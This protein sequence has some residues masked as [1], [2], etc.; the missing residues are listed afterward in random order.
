VLAEDIRADADVPSF[1][2]SAMDGYAVIAA[3]T[4]GATRDEPRK[5]T[6]LAE[7]PAGTVVSEK[8]VPGTA[9]RIM[10][11]A[12][13]PLGAD[14]VVPFEETDEAAAGPEDTDSR[15]REV[16]I[17]RETKAGWN[18]RPAG[19]DVRQG[20]L[21]MQA[22]R[23]VRPSELGM[24]AA[25]GRAQ[26]EV[27]RKARVAVITSGNELADV[28]ERPGPGQIRDSNQYSLLGQVLSTGAEVSAL[29]R[30]IDERGELERVLSNAVEISDMVIVS[31]GV[32]VGDYDFVKDTLAKL[33]DIRFWKVEIKPGK[34][35][36][37]GD[38]MG[39]PLFGLPGNPVS[40]MVTFDVFVRPAIKRM[41]GLESVANMTV[42][43]VVT[44]SVRHKI[45]RREFVRATTVWS[46]AGYAATP[47]G[48]QGSG[49]LSSMVNANSYIILPEETGDATAGETVRIMLF[50]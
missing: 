36:A 42:S 20:E 19:D 44:Q 34:P 35:L 29:N 47:T 2:N 41:M 9:V 7:A 13:I 16:L 38:L 43:G 23:R 5:L 32:S 46:D 4:S 10:T 48:L 39:K 3:D 14:A 30:V 37:Y 27:Y 45:G 17:Y 8:I 15:D 31:G 33:G 1:A 22:G 24:L 21:V 6:V 12:P 25:L 11:G 18:V 50:E 40:S 28:S 26:V 49:K